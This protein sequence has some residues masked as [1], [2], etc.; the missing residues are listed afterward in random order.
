MIYANQLAQLLHPKTFGKY[1]NAFQGKTVVLVAPGVSLKSFVPIE[2]AIYVGVNGAI[3]NEKII[4]DYFFVHDFSGQTKTYIE[5]LDNPK[6]KKFYGIPLF[7]PNPDIMIPESVAIRHQAERYYVCLRSENLLKSF[8]PIDSAQ[9]P[10]DITNHALIGCKS[11]VFT[12]MQF[13]LFC[14]PKTIYLVGC[15]CDINGYFDGEKNLLNIESVLNSW[16]QLKKFAESNY[17]ETEI[18][19]INPVGLTGLFPQYIQ[20]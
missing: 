4:F 17:P 13:I 2:N 10:L 7:S 6:I 1:K 19:S 20:I 18:F 16:Q 12:A 14:N 15:D 11:I 5:L 9:F 8:N 3:R